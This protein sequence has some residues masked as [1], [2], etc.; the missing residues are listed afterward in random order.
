MIIKYKPQY[1]KAIIDLAKKNTDLWALVEQNLLDEKGIVFI[2]LDD[3][4]KFQGFICGTRMVDNGALINYIATKHHNIIPAIGLY[5]HFR[6]Y[7]RDN[8]IN[9][10]C[11]YRENT[12]EYKMEVL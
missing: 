3:D 2:Y 10:L 8:S 9:K 12:K 7:C 5:R 4:R 1:K 6:K 11:F